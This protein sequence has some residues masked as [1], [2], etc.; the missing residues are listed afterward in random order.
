MEA[1]RYEE[2]ARHRY[3]EDGGGRRHSVLAQLQGRAD[4]D[5]HHH[6]G[7][8]GRQQTRE[9]ELQKGSSPGEDTV[10]TEFFTGVSTLVLG[11]FRLLGVKKRLS[12]PILAMNS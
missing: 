10:S 8:P 11:R 7:V 3:Q 1:R 4:D 5:G 2:R 12:L 9:C 6:E